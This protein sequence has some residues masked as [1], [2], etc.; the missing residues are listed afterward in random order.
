M[1][2]AVYTIVNIQYVYTY[3][4][5][6]RD[7]DRQAETQADRQTHMNFF[8][9]FSVCLFVEKIVVFSQ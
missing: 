5:T 6:H 3:T 4:H 8:V 2:F 7:I 9:F 1:F